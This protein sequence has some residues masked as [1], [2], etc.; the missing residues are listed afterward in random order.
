[1]KGTI[2]KTQNLQLAHVYKGCNHEIETQITEMTANT[3]VIRDISRVLKVLTY[4]VT[5]TLKK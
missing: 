1:M 3:S 4:K 2:S 5:N